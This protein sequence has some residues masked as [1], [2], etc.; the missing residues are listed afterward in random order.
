MNQEQIR[1]KLLQIRDTDEY[2]T[3][4][5]SGKKS[6][7]VDG[8][9]KAESREIILHNKNFAGDNELM[10][11]AIHEYAHH[12]QF[13]SSPIPVSTRAHTTHFFSLFHSLLYEAEALGIYAN[14]FERIEE[15]VVVTR[16]IRDKVLAVDGQLMKELGGLLLEAQELCER[17][18]ASFHD[19]LDRVLRLPRAA[20]A[21][22][23]KTRTL[24]L[25]PRPGFETMK[26][27][28]RIGDPD[29]R[30]E[31]EQA[32]LG[33][34]SLDMVKEQL[35]QAR[36]PD[37]AR[38][39]MEQLAAEKRRLERQIERLRRRLDEIE[40]KLEQLTGEVV[41]VGESD[42]EGI[43]G[44]RGEREPGTGIPPREIGLRAGQD[45]ERR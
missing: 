27:L 22:I 36:A 37:G 34:K 28:S 45:G 38:D 44:G 9:Y 29:L 31:A 26:T 10:Y 35:R 18:H 6:R 40:R 7:K 20:A 25:D 24:D 16:R 2:F 3:V 30:K 4:I 1:E 14:P 19:Y 5:L 15:F 41:K 11:T 32:L 42:T 33:D 23:I 39:P 43:R 12:L 21:S 17:H 8:L 13:T